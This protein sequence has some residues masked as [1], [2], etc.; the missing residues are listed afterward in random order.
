MK[1]RRRLSCARASAAKWQVN[2]LENSTIVLT[3]GNRVP[4]DVELAD[5]AG[6][7]RRPNDVRPVEVEVHR[8][9][10]A[11]EHHLGSQEDVHAHH[12]GLDRRV[13]RLDFGPHRRDRHQWCTSGSAL[14]VGNIRLSSITTQPT[15]PH[16]KISPPIDGQD[17]ADRARERDRAKREE[18][19]AE[20][21]DEGPVA[22]R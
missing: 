11:E 21:D 10:A 20:A 3:T 22:G 16:R 9:E 2:A 4:V 8:E 12:P 7:R 1:N 17:D 6:R 13:L 14:S 15:T 19:Q 5:V 18:Q